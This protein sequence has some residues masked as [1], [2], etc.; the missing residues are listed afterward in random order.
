MSWIHSALRRWTRQLDAFISGEIGVLNT[1]TAEHAQLVARVEH[2]EDLLLTGAPWEAAEVYAKLRRE[3]L[4]HSRVEKLTLKPVVSRS[5]PAKQCA[6][7]QAKLENTMA[8]LDRVC[9]QEEEWADSFFS[10]A[11]IVRDHVGFF[12]GRIFPR[13]VPRL[14]HSQLLGYDRAYR[15]RKRQVAK[16]LPQPSW[17]V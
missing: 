5:R 6:K 3:L 11:A 16:D 12:E 7:L 10:L 4:S 15:A 2:V 13:A 9:P 8:V 1:L 17:R 14:T